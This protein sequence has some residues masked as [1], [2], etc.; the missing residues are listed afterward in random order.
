MFLATE[1]AAELCAQ[2]MFLAA[3]LLSEVICSV[4]VIFR[5]FSETAV[6]SAVI[7][8]T[9]IL[10]VYTKTFHP[11]LL[12][13]FTKITLY[14]TFIPLTYHD[15]ECQRAPSLGIYLKNPVFSHG[16]L[17]VAFSRARSYHNIGAISRNIPQKSCFLSRSTI[18]ARSYHNIFVQVIQTQTQGQ[19]R[20]RTLTPNV[21]FKEI[22][23]RY[24]LLYNQDLP[25]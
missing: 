24:V 9:R 8:H 14:P 3:E 19:I 18:W 10:P 16:Q 11:L 20:D 4:F 1:L 21:V 7:F 23:W 17:Y 15:T 2:V 5:L 12:Q 25:L 22:L 6:R 13:Y